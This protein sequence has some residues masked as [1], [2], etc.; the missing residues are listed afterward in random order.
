MS[1]RLVSRQQ[2]LHGLSWFTY[3]FGHTNIYSYHVAKLIL[4]SSIFSLNL[5]L[6]LSLYSNQQ[7]EEGCHGA[8]VSSPRLE[9]T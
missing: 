1:V 5:S 4:S 7:G 6:L 3:F 9:L 2:T 8:C